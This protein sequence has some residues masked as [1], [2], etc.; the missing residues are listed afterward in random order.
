MKSFG[1]SRMEDIH[2][3]HGGKP[4]APHRHNYYTVLLVQ[5]AKGQH[6]ID[7]KGF[8]LKDGFW[9]HVDKVFHVIMDEPPVPHPVLDHKEGEKKKDLFGRN[10]NRP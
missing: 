8:E 9:V 6:F 1:I 7:F 2:D 5:K 3:K 10:K 4:D